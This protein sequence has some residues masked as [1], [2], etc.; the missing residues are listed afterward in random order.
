LFMLC[1]PFLYFLRA[2]SLI[3]PNDVINGMASR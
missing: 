1:A 3:R 2:N